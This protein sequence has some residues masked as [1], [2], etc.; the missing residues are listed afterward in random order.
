V[1]VR[2]SPRVTVKLEAVVTVLPAV[3]TEMCPV[4]ARLGTWVVIFVLELTVQPA[5][6]ELNLSE[7]GEVKPVPLTVTAVPT[8][9]EVGVKEVT[10]AVSGR[11]FGLVAVTDP[12]VTLT[13]PEVALAGTL[14]S[15]FSA[16]S[17][18]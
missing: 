15:I 5:A 13:N 8:P 12:A 10:V 9:P 2:L 1:T 6:T 17:T 16:E 14:M 18:L 11:I 4:V 3:V 7:Q